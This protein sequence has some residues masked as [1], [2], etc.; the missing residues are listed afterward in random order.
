[1]CKATEEQ[2]FS[3]FSNT[4]EGLGVAAIF[5]LW[6][7][8]TC[9]PWWA[10]KGNPFLLGLYIVFFKSLHWASMPTPFSSPD[11]QL[12]LSTLEE[13]KR[14]DHIQFHSMCKMPHSISSVCMCKSLEVA[15]IPYLQWNSEWLYSCQH[16]AS[17][18]TSVPFLLVHFYVQHLWHIVMEGPHKSCLLHRHNFSSKRGWLLEREEAILLS[19]IGTRNEIPYNMNGDSPQAPDI[20]II[21]CWIFAITKINSGNLKEV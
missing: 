7:S 9:Q 19:S 2:V 1:M 10:S 6:Q 18:V 21:G 8:S 4:R 12:L 5:D 16:K 20:F 11:R 3:C 17:G 13:G 14:K 15:L